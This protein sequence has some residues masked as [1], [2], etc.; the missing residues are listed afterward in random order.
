MSNRFFE[1]IRFY[2]SFATVPNNHAKCKTNAMNVFFFSNL[3]F[4]YFDQ[5]VVRFSYTQKFVLN[6]TYFACRSNKIKKEANMNHHHN[7]H[8]E[9]NCRLIGLCI[10]LAHYYHQKYHNHHYLDH[11]F[12]DNLHN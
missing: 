9:H 3:L 6:E 11:H 4:Y 7:L 10:H 5:E 12:Q 1:S 2:L 8:Q